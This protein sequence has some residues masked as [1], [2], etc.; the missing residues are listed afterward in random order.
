[1]KSLADVFAARL[2][3]ELFGGSEQIYVASI[4]PCS[5]RDPFENICPGFSVACSGVYTWQGKQKTFKYE[6]LCVGLEPE[7]NERSKEDDGRYWTAEYND[8]D[9]DPFAYEI[10]DQS[11]FFLAAYGLDEKR[12][13]ESQNFYAEKNLAFRLP[14]NAVDLLLNKKIDRSIVVF[15]DVH[16]KDKV[17]LN[18]QW[19]AF[20]EAIDARG[21]FDALKLKYVYRNG[22]EPQR[23]L[24]KR[25]VFKPKVRR[26]RPL[27]LDETLTPFHEEVLMEFSRQ[28]FSDESTVCKLIAR[29]TNTVPYFIADEACRIVGIDKQAVFENAQS[30][31]STHRR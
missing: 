19:Q 1:M 17:E 3:H 24:I 22:Y 16:L 15:K 5:V 29:D 9:F 13:L 7:W 25:V 18:E 26:N 23:G 28:P 20:L 10:M 27:V 14:S 6:N 2:G 12:I 8:G 31:K 21:G 30:N 11:D 4:N